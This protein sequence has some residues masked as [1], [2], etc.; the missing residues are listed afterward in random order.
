M[1]SKKVRLS[2]WLTLACE[3]FKLKVSLISSRE[4]G[5]GHKTI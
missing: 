5:S 1:I 4:V 2:D 3:Q